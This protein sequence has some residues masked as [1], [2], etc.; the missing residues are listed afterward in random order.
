MLS[1]LHI[2]DLYI[3]LENLT[4]NRIPATYISE[5]LPEAKIPAIVYLIDR[6]RLVKLC[7]ERGQI[8][9][10]EACSVSQFSWMHTMIAATATNQVAGL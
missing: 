7:R 3:V 10:F 2:N 8:V 6:G 4:S 1:V 5:F 9:G